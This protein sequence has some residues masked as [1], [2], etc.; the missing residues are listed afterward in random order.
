MNNSWV[1]HLTRTLLLISFYV[2]SLSEASLD[3]MLRAIADRSRRRILQVLNERPPVPRPTPGLCAGE[4]EQRLHLAQSTISHHMSVL[5][6][7]GLIQSKKQGL[8]VWYRRNN[9]SLRELGHDLKKSL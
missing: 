2:M 3:R 5:R 6:R 7:A 9:A 4:I 8:W 1:C